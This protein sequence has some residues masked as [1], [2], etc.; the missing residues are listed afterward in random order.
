MREDSMFTRITVMVV[1]KTSMKV[2]LMNLITS[3]KNIQKCMN[4][5]LN[6]KWRSSDY[7]LKAT[8]NIKVRLRKR[9]SLISRLTGLL[10]WGKGLRAV[11][12]KKTAAMRGLKGLHRNLVVTTPF[13]MAI[14]QLITRKGLLANL[15][16]LTPRLEIVVHMLLPNQEEAKM[17]PLSLDEWKP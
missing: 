13:L 8:L 12:L 15:M 4:K 2:N 10:N 14:K 16:G 3:T 1:I 11:Q 7:V 5:K 9:W 17:R 6:S